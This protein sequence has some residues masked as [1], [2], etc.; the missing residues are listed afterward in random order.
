MIKPQTPTG[1]LYVAILFPGTDARMV[2]PYTLGASSLNH[3]KKLAAYVASPCASAIGFPI[4][5]VISVAMS[6]WY[7][8]IS[9]Y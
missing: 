5:Y 7:A 3:L 4:S 6:S 9:S 1:S 8:T 2:S